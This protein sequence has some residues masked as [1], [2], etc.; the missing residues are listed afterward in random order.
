MSLE[1]PV[2]REGNEDAPDRF[3]SSDPD[4]F[5]TRPGMPTYDHRQDEENIAHLRQELARTPRRTPLPQ[6]ESAAPSDHHKEPTK[7]AKV[8]TNVVDFVP[9]LGSG[10]MILE[11]LRGK[12][13]GTDRVISGSARIIHGV[14]GAIFLPLDVTGI[15][16]LVSEAGKAGVKIGIRLLEQQPLKRLVVHEGTQREVTKLATRGNMRREA[17]EKITAS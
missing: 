3:V 13:Y 7:L 4:R 16:A 10:K 17:Q 15:G 1:R 9:I 6:P 12:Q 14:S 2:F 8:A 5:L 11:G